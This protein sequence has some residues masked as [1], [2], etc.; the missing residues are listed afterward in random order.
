MTAAH[1]TLK[2]G[3]WV[4]VTRV[5]NGKSVRVRITDRGPYGKKNRIIDLS[6]AAAAAID[7][8]RAGVVKVR[9]SVVGGP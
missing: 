4:V 6:K 2:L 1:R 7:M 8:I 5:D 3:T 9:V